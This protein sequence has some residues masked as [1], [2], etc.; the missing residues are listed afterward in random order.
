MYK[1]AI[2]KYIYL[3]KV[4]G[5]K[6]VG[7]DSQSDKADCRSFLHPSDFFQS[8]NYRLHHALPHADHPAD[9]ILSLPCTGT[10]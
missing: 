3:L 6:G 4:Q 2:M 9:P 5:F 10:K 7:V 1:R 8:C